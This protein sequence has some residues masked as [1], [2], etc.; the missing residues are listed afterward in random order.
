MSYRCSLATS[1]EED[2]EEQVIWYEEEDSRGGIELAD[3]WRALFGQA[4]EK[5]ATAP[6]RHGLAP[7]N[8]K[9]LPHQTVRQ[10]LFR[11]WK[12]GVGWRILF[13]IRE[14]VQIVTVHQ[15]RH[16]RRRYMHEE[17]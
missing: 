3:R 1:A 6:H 17:E 13:S 16:E 8:G 5:L 2:V 14:D 10:M 7:E 4:I 9:W 11:P 12:S 15:V